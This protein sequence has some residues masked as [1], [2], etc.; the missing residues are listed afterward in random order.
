MDEAYLDNIEQAAQLHDVGKIG[1]PDAVLHKPG[2]LNETE[3]EMM[4]KHCGFGKHILQRLSPDEELVMRHHAD[5]GARILNVG[6]SPLMEM[7]MRIAL[8]HHEWWD[9]QRIP[10]GLRGKN[11]PLE[12]RIT[13]VADVFDALSTKRCYKKAFPL[14][15]MHGNHA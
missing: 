1:V 13:A 14:E 4:Q 8:T 15:R 11:I 10:L 9:G 3:F 5:V 7:A 12:G 6:Q 2:R